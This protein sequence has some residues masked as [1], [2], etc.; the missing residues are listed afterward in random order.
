MTNQ[1]QTSKKQEVYLPLDFY[2]LRAPA[3]P[4]QIFCRLSDVG[5]VALAD[6]GDQLDTAW[7]TSLASSYRLLRELALRPDI[8]QAVAIASPALQIGLERLQREEGTPA[9]RKKAYS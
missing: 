1:K 5:Q 6:C 9:R 2:M 8:A 4:A 3:L 7:Q